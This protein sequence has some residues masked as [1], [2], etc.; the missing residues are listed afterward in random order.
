MPLAGGGLQRRSL[1]HSLL[2]PI[3]C[4]TL[5]TCIVFKESE[6]APHFFF[7]WAQEKK[8]RAAPGVKKKR[9]A[10]A[11]LG[12]TVLLSR[13]AEHRAVFQP[14][15]YKADTAK[16]LR[17]LPLM[18]GKGEML[19]GFPQHHGASAETEKYCPSCTRCAA[20]LQSRNVAIDCR[21]C[22]ACNDA[23]LT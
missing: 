21:L 7:S 18:R 6:C 2:T 19:R 16:P 8:K 11:D 13:A 4:S 10:G 14:V 12:R 22:R 17:P 1:C 5:Q 23:H 3:Y 15:W 20:I 9:S